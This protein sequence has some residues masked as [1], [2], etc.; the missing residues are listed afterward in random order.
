MSRSSQIELRQR[1]SQK[2]GR[3]MFE[4]VRRIQNIDVFKKN[5]IRA[6]T[7][8]V[9]SRLFQRQRIAFWEGKTGYFR[10]SDFHHEAMD[11]PNFELFSMTLRKLKNNPTYQSA[12][13]F[14]DPKIAPELPRGPVN[15]ILQSMKIFYNIFHEKMLSELLKNGSVVFHFRPRMK[16]ESTRGNGRNTSNRQSEG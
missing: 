4:L 10:S 16:A 2:I 14:T 3:T 15:L 9:E 12:S 1:L 13:V 8:L 7:D 6:A 5:R 11:N